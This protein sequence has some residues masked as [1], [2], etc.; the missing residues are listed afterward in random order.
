M[1]Y[2]HCEYWYDSIDG[3]KERIDNPYLIPVT[4]SIMKGLSGAI[5]GEPGNI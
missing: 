3:V 1:P 4:P 5:R 2:L